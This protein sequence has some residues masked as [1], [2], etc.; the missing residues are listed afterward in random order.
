MEFDVDNDGRDLLVPMRF[1]RVVE[2]RKSMKQEGNQEEEVGE[3]LI[4]Q[5]VERI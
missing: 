3:E 5:R 2:A 4:N 1:G